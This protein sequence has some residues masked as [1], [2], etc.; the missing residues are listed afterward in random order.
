V[1]GRLKLVGQAAA[2]GLVAALFALLIWKVAR[3]D[4]PGGAA[5]AFQRGEQVA[6]PEFALS[7]L[8]GEGK[9]GLASLRGKVV[10]INFWAA[11]CD[12]CKKE[13]P[14]FE[15][16]WQRY[17]GRGVEFV[18]V[19]TQDYSGAARDFVGR[20]EV[21]YPNVRDQNGRVL[22]DYGGL[23]LPRTFFVGRNGRIVG[24]IH[25]EASAEDLES[26]IE[27]ALST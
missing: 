23:P 26:G 24:Y 7:R 3:D 27:S 6:A 25:G 22:S 8:E 17:R 13:A 12:P 11:W 9:L 18:G 16:A 15:A 2:V 14:L 10:V 19:N 20:Y 21:T 1:T 4:D 5:A